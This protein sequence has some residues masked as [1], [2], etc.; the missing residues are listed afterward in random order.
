MDMTLVRKL[1]HLR[2][3]QNT[4]SARTRIP[5]TVEVPRDKTMMTQRTQLPDQKRPNSMDPPDKYTRERVLRTL[6]A[7]FNP[8]MLVP[9][10]ELHYLASVTLNIATR[11]THIV[12]APKLSPLTYFEHRLACR[13]A[14]QT[15]VS[16]YEYL[17][18]PYGCHTY[19]F[20][21]RNSRQLLIMLYNVANYN[22][23]K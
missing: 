19:R 18:I 12:T 6:Q 21:T 15:H 3:N 10:R 2:S 16:S 1:Q 23:S 20:K 22:L 13:Y 9:P 17:R 5:A 7:I 8:E 14:P 4:T 11:H